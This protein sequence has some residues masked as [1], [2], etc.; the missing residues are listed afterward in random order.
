MR[1]SFFLALGLLMTA[2]IL[3]AQGHNNA[4]ERR[5]R[6]EITFASDTKVGGTVLKAGDYEIS[7]DKEKVTF[8]RQSDHKK[9]AEVLC[10]GTDIGKK[11]ADTRT[12]ITKDPFGV[13]MLRSLI[14]EGSNILHTFD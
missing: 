6:V 1:K 9:M 11:Q 3:Q 13:P 14:I 2:G 12:E 8:V 7:C 4:T 10:K 5:A